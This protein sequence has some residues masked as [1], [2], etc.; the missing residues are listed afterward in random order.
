MSAPTNDEAKTVRDSNLTRFF[1]FQ[2][3]ARNF[4]NR[5]QYLCCIVATAEELVEIKQ[6]DRSFEKLMTAFEKRMRELE[7]SSVKWKWLQDCGVVRILDM[8]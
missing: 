1:E 7:E 3:Q 2:Q 4:H 8:G 5:K 6:A